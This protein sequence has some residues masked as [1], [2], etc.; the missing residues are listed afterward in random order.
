MRE[1]LTALGGRL[2]II[3]APRRGTTIKAIIPYRPQEAGQTPEAEV[4]S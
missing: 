4:V 1:R 2:E 3:S